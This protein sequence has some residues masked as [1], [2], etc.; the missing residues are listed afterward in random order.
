MGLFCPPI[1]LALLLQARPRLTKGVLVTQ[2]VVSVIYTMQ[3]L[4]GWLRKTARLPQN[5]ETVQRLIQPF[6][7]TFSAISSLRYNITRSKREA[8]CRPTF[9]GLA[10]NALGRLRLI[11]RE[12]DD[13][14]LSATSTPFSFFGGEHLQVK[15]DERIFH[16]AVVDIVAAGAPA[17]GPL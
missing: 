8:L 2:V 13:A 15:T 16:G 3:F 14:T 5:A 11:G 12:Q 9:V 10:G 6:T 1:A 17:G 4:Y 7:F